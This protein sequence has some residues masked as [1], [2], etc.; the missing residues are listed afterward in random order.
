[1]L[2]A[3]LSGPVQADPLERASRSSPLASKRGVTAIAS[4]G[5]DRLM[6]VGQRGHVLLSVDGSDTWSQSPVPVSSDLTA[7]QFVDAKHGFAVG[8]DGVILASED[9]GAR[10]RVLLDGKMA[11]ALVLAQLQKQPPTAERDHLLGEAQRNVEAGP[12]KPWLD[13]YFSSPQ[14]GFV[15]GAYNLI[16]ETRDGGQS[17]RSW[18]DRSDNSEKMFN[19]YGVRAHQGQLFVAGEAG[20]L[21]RLDTARQR[22][23]QLDSGYSGSFFGLLDAGESLVAYGMRGQVRIT[24]DAGKTWKPVVSGLSSSITAATRSDDGRL[25][26]VDQVGNFSVSRDGGQS[27]ARLRQSAGMPV[28][29]LTATA[30][31]LVLAGPRGIRRVPFPKD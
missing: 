30:H 23:V 21:M 29:A 13:L 15:V 7:V 3:M 10:W 18:Y 28:A 22:F 25:W 8:H 12:D 27:F 31:A 19:L 1:M 20:L 5:S 16:L 17:W 14:H 11:N 26:L 6:A 24:R 9:A 4:S 2:L